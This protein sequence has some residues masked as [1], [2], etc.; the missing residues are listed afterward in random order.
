MKE[1][2]SL[3]LSQDPTTV[4]DAWENEIAIQAQ[5]AFRDVHDKFLDAI[6]LIPQSRND[7][8]GTTATVAYV[9]RDYIVLASLGDSRA[10][11][12]TKKAGKVGAIQLTRDHVASDPV[13]KSAIESRGGSVLQINGLDRVNGTLA[14]SRSLGDSHLS[15][16]L[17]QTPDV[18]TFARGT[19]LDMCGELGNSVRFPCFLI[20]AS[21]GLWDVLP[22]TEVVSSIVLYIGSCE[23]ALLNFAQQVHLVL[24]TIQSGDDSGGQSSNHAALQRAAETLVHEAF[25]RGSTDNIGVCVIGL[26]GEFVAGY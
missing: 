6:A 5:N 13:E 17:S 11:L 25:V 3:F 18:T 20:L 7:E 19:I 1:R 26:S 16:V 8:S 21:D 15:S 9:T 23:V 2:L 10:V 12:S 24:D 4:N 22:N 14:V